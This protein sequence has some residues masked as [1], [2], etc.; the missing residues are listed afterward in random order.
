MDTLF[1][2]YGKIVQRRLLLDKY[3]Q[4][5]RGIG[6]VRFSQ[7]TEAQAAIAGLNGAV[8]EGGTQALSVKVAEDFSRSKSMMNVQGGFPGVCRFSG[9]DG[10]VGLGVV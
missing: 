2:P 7:R 5:P 4:M 1:S 3:T 8:P 9:A 10:R 6:F